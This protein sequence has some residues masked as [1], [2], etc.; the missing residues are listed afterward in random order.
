MNQFLQQNAGPLI[1]IIVYGGL[2]AALAIMIARHRR[3]GKVFP[4]L[5]PDQVLYREGWAS[6]R[7]HLNWRTRHCSAG[8]CV[9]VAVTNTEV[10]VWLPFP[11]S[12]FAYETD[13]EHCFPRRAINGI[14]ERRHWLGR[15]LLID[16]LDQDQEPRRIELQLRRPSDFL[17]ALN[18]TTTVS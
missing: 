12:V 18:S 16:Y 17:K 15:S 1:L 11:F 4:P 3:F 7:S 9:W 10:R 8:G 2:G 13:L 5:D 14:E 6:A